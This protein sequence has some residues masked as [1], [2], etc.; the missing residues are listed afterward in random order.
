VTVHGVSSELRSGI[1][2]AEQHDYTVPKEVTITIFGFYLHSA[3]PHR[4]L[5]VLCANSVGARFHSSIPYVGCVEVVGVGRGTP[6]RGAVERLTCTSVLLGS[7]STMQQ[8]GCG[9]VVPRLNFIVT[10]IYW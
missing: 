9:D 8:E 3:P 5:P 10:F 4:V 2:L 1:W 7:R 6:N